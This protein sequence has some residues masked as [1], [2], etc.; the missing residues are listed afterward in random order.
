M[1]YG[2]AGRNNGLIHVSLIKSGRHITLTVQDN[3]IGFPEGFDMKKKAGYGLMLVQMLSKQLG[4]SLQME[5][6]NGAKSVLTFDTRMLTRVRMVPRKTA[7][8]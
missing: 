2:F 6:L 8:L 7:Q 5:N 3:G 4:G 1:K